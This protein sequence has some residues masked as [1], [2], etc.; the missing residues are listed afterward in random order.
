MKLITTQR[1]QK[2]WF[3]LFFLTSFLI[4][5]SLPSWAEW[6]DKD[7]KKNS[8]DKKT[9][10]EKDQ[11]Q[12]A[13]RKEMSKKMDTPAPAPV[14]QAVPPVRRAAAAT[15]RSAPTRPARA[16]FGDDPQKFAQAIKRLGKVLD[17][18]SI[19]KLSDPKA[20]AALKNV[21]SG[22]NQRKTAATP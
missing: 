15:N 16:M 20:K 19:A 8:K 9:T 1:N 21:S 10:A 13:D 14:V 11:G 5:S 18:G 3:A 7:S 2:M 17:K 12:K 6:G 4:H 22:I